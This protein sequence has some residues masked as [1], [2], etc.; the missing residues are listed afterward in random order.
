MPTWT[1]RLLV[2]LLL[3]LAPAT[4][5]T[6]S[7]NSR[8]E[9]SSLDASSRQVEADVTATLHRDCGR[10][11]L[12]SAA[13]CSVAPSSGL[14]TST[15]VSAERAQQFMV[16]SGFPPNRAAG[17]LDSIDGPITARLVRPGEQFG[18]YAGKP[19]GEGSFLTKSVFGSPS[20]AQDALY[21]RPFN[22]PATYRQPVTSTGRSIVIEGGIKN[23]APGVRQTI[24]INRGAFGFGTGEPLLP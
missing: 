2:A 12:R 5:A 6:L 1:H 9:F 20:Q 18:R 7:A 11:W 8:L 3:V 14:R 22:N 23:G 21:L 4:T 24:I 10:C 15:V 13:E 16:K 19:T 17:F